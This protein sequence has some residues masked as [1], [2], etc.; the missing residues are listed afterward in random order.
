MGGR[1][2]FVLGLNAWDHDVSACLLRDGAVE[3]AIA[4]ERLTRVKHDA[5]FYEEVVDYC[6]EA[7]GI[8]LER[9]DLVVR[10]C[11]VLPVPEIE[12]RL[13]HQRRDYYL[14][15]GERERALVH[16]LFL[17]P[18]SES[19][20]T[21]SHHLAHAWSAFA[22]SPFKDGAVMVVDGVGSYRRD[23][24]EP[25][26]AGSEAPPLARESE[27]WYRFKGATLEPVRKFWLE[28]AAGFLNDE[29]WHMAA[30]RGS[31]V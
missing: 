28:P 16:P 29:F 15:P 21:V 10:N 24:T 4:K 3:V 17:K 8:P 25:V 14:M 22:V 27:S 2:L 20:A 11:Y 1:D 19:M 6:L 7:A 18:D 26:P 30:P 23:C 31:N 12:R 13:V 9:V 5:G